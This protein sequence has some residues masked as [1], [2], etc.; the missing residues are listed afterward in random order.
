MTS[1]SLKTFVFA[2]PHEYDKSTF[3]KISTLESVIK[4]LRFSV[5]QKRR[6]RVDSS[7]I[8]KKISVFENTLWHGQDSDSESYLIIF[9]V[10]FDLWL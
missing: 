5:P 4:N 8:W 7:Y 2:R 3:L 10:L 9:S 6:L 1:S